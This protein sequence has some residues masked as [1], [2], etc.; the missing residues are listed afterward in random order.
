MN[1]GNKVVVTLAL[2]LCAQ[3]QPSIKVTSPAEGAIVNPGQTLTITV[4]VSGGAFDE[5]AARA[6][7]DPS[8]SKSLTSPP[9]QFTFTIPSTTTP[10][11]VAVAAMGHT[12]ARMV[13]AVP[14]AVDV[15]RPDSP[16]S[17]TS[18]FSDL[19][20][21]VGAAVSCTFRASTATAR[22]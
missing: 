11:V 18:L 4:A 2:A 15:E 6:P 22:Q 9:Y 16:V 7:W 21:D 1:V 8:I 3:A 10:G 12:S 20:E 13:F 19:D 5:V 14:V 17:V